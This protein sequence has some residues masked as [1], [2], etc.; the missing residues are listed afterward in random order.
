[1]TGA[2]AVAVA[3]GAGVDAPTRAAGCVEA[4]SHGAALRPVPCTSWMRTRF[5]RNAALRPAPV[6]EAE[7]MFH[8]CENMDILHNR[9]MPPAV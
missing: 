4:R 7:E 2:R 3:R 5:F 1:M 6:R 8:H 9:G